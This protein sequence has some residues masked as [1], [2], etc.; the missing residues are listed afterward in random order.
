M[1]SFIVSM[2]YRKIKIFS[3]KFFNFTLYLAIEII[4]QSNILCCLSHLHFC[5]LLTGCDVYVRPTIIWFGFIWYFVS[6]CR[7]SQMWH[8]LADRSPQA[9]KNPELEQVCHKLW[10]ELRLRTESVFGLVSPLSAASVL[11]KSNFHIFMANDKLLLLL[12][13]PLTHSRNKGRS[14]SHA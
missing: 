1:K 6:I 11:N 4:F 5:C 10:A 7:L 3:I 12:G 8:Q 9:I 13:D 14:S 2:R